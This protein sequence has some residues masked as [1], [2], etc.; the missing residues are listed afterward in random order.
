[1]LFLSFHFTKQT[2]IANDFSAHH[3]EASGE[4]SLLLQ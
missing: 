4:E 2:L 3:Q 1:M